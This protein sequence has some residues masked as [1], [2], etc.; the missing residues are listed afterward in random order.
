MKD[1]DNFS[2]ERTRG[3]CCSK[4][5]LVKIVSNIAIDEITKLVGF[6]EIVNRDDVFDAPL[7]K[8]LDYVR[9]D[10]SGGT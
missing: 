1:G 3:K 6:G 7:V 2:V 10:E 5:I 8:R 9:A 4:I